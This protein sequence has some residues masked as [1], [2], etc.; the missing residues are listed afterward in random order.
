MPGALVRS[1]ILSGTADKIRDAGQSPGVIARRA[2]IPAAALRDPD[3]MVSGRAVM[4]FFDLAASACRRRPWGLEVSADAR[5][6]SVIGPLWAL[7]RNARTVR[8]LCAD[9]ARNYDLYT[10]AALMSFDPFPGR[11]VLGWSAATGQADTEV[12]I[13]EYAIGVLLNEIRAHAPPGWTP[14]AVHFRHG[15]PRDLRVHRKLLGPHLRFDS[16]R[17][18]IEIEDAILDLPLRGRLPGRRALVEKVLR[19][20]EGVPVPSTALQVESLVRA[21]L[22]IAP[23]GIEDVARAMSVSIRTLQERL[24]ASRRSFRTIKDEV[25]RD[26]AQKYLQHSGMSATQIADL[27]G[28]AD[29]TSFSRSFRRWHGRS[30]RRFRPSLPG[31]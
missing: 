25:R 27:L 30:V 17:N 3:L 23:C 10:S 2:G 14:P 12:Q 7:L 22:P 20:Q 26:L 28:Y 5:L 31:E 1:V 4:R 19:L 29:L 15:A 9:L 24:Q 18:A 11:G 8:E 6:G 16:D 21:L 13:A